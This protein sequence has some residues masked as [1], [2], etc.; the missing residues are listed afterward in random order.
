METVRALRGISI[1]TSSPPA[2]PG[3]LFL[4]RLGLLPR[5]L[6]RVPP[7]LLAYRR[8]RAKSLYSLVGG[9]G[10]EPPTLSV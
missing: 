3:G 1:P 10:L 5:T 6:P 9:D 2:H 7:C 4:R 8:K